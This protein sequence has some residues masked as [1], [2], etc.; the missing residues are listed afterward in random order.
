MIQGFE[1][2]Y[3][4]G[5]REDLLRLFDFLLDRAQTAEDFD[6]A[7]LA[8]NA[9]QASVQGQLSRTPFICRKAGQSPF[10]RELVVPCRGSGHVAP[11][12]IEGNAMVNI[13]AVR[14]SSKMTT[15]EPGCAGR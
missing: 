15:T 5:A 14:H 4:Q 3:T 8:V 1:G 7:Q 2:R 10:V 11:Y 9:I 13:L 12:E 6:D